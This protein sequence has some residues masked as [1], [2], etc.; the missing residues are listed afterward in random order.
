[1]DPKAI[2]DEDE[3]AVDPLAVCSLPANSLD[4]RR[5][6]IRD[7]ILPHAVETESLVK[8]RGVAIELRDAP[9]LADKLDRLIELERD[10]CSSIGFERTTGAT[11]GR[12]RLEIRGVDPHAAVFQ[13][14][15]MPTRATSPAG[16]L[17][18]ALGIGTL[19]SFVVCCV[20]PVAAVALV[21]AAA[22]P[23]TTLDGPVPI[24]LGALL[25]GGIGWWWLGRRPA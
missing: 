19:G 14:L 8:G 15:Q 4:E 13:S 2:S 11:S 16:R 21:G 22:A 3:R 1:M 12:L 10:C 23:L 5:Q 7:E 17:L 18:K 24:A 20:L 6:W 25:G 9:G